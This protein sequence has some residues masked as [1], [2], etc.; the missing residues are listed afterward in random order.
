[1]KRKNNLK[2]CITFVRKD[3]ATIEDMVIV[4]FTH[5]NRLK[6][7]REV[8][9][10][11]THG[12]TKWVETTNGGRKMWEYSSEDLNIGDLLSLGK[13]KSLKKNLKQ[14]GIKKWKPIYQL[15]NGEEVSYDKVLASP[16]EEAQTLPTTAN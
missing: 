6:T 5:K 11:F 13:D 8:L 9:E 1:M 2:T 3:I 12:I 15:V 10:A 16:N 4:K 14:V 7:P